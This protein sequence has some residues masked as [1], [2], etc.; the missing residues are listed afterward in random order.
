MLK[1][2]LIS[3]VSG[4]CTPYTTSNPTW[5][6]ISEGNKFALVAKNTASAITW[7]VAKKKHAKGGY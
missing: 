3:L 6:D 2:I 1:S 4:N 7:V 5:K